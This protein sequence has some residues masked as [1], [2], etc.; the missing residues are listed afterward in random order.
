MSYW[1]GRHTAESLIDE[2][3]TECTL[4]EALKSIYNG[5]RLRRLHLECNLLQITDHLFDAL[6][7]E[8]FLWSYLVLEGKQ[9]VAFQSLFKQK[10]PTLYLISLHM[11]NSHILLTD[12]R[13]LAQE[14]RSIP[15]VV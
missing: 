2:R 12:L 8:E 15:D 4:P 9:K 3:L 10:L 13:G 5:T 1:Q 11:A 7:R 14:N 6:I